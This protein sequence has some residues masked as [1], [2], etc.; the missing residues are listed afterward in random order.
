MW[1]LEREVLVGRRSTAS[2]IYGNITVAVTDPVADC[3][4]TTRPLDDRSHSIGSGDIV[5]R[6]S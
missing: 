3:E 1:G 6:G 4:V 5:Y 2:H